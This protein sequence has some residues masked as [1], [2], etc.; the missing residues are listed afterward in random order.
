MVSLDLSKQ[1]EW[2]NIVCCVFLMFSTFC[3]WIAFKNIDTNK[4]YERYRLFSIFSLICLLIAF[5]LFCWACVVNTTY[6]KVY[7]CLVLY[8][9]VL[10]CLCAAIVSKGNKLT[11]DQ[12][13][14]S[15][16]ETDVSTAYKLT[17]AEG[18][19]KAVLVGVVILYLI[20]KENTEKREQQHLQN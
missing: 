8:T 13:N 16:D 7:A 18:V 4:E 19:L 12:S 2:L 3:T 10:L 6:R 5:L 14:N 9:F 20:A 11:S 1:P 15:I 17:I